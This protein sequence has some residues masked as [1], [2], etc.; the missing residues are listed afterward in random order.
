MLIVNLSNG[1]AGFVIVAQRQIVA[2]EMVENAEFHQQ[3][4]DG[5]AGFTP[6]PCHDRTL[7]RKR[8][9]AKAHGAG[10]PRRLIVDQGSSVPT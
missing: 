1:E 5:E 6:N 7:S 4:L 8:E 9:R 2:V 3:W 10:R